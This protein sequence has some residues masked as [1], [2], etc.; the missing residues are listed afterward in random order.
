MA[1]ASTSH[2]LQ[3]ALELH[4]RGA[5]GDA[6]M[7]YAEVLQNDPANSDAYYYLGMVAC[8]EGR[9]VDGVEFARKSLDNDPQNPR[10]QVLLGRALSALGRRDEALRCF[11]RAIGLAPQLAQAHASRADVL[12][13][14]GRAAEA[15]ES[16]D[17]ALSLLPEAA[18]DW[19][20][21]GIALCMLRRLEEAITSF[22]RAI[23]NKPDIAQMH[24][25]RAKV[26]SD[27][28]RYDDALASFEKALQIEPRL[29]EAWVDRATV[30]KE[31]KQYSESLNA[32]D[33][34]LAIK[35]D[36]AEALLCRGNVLFLLKRYDKALAVCDQA[37]ALRPD[38]AE[39]HFGRGAIFLA[40]KQY[41]DAL[42][43]YEAALNFRPDFAEAAIACGNVFIE[44]KQYD[45]ALAAN[46]RAASLRPDIAEAWAGCGNA[47]IELRRYDEALVA[48]DRAVTL[49]PALAEAWLGRANVFFNRKQYL[50]ALAAF[51]SAISLQ[52]DLA[53]GWAGR[54]N[55]LVELRRY[56]EALAACD[57]ASAL[58]PDLLDAW[59]GRA[60]IFFNC[61][62]Y[63]DAA[64]ACERILELKP[65]FAR[66]WF[67]YGSALLELQ[68]CDRA[69]VAYDKATALGPETDYAEGQR[70]LAKLHMCDWSALEADTRL[71]LS[72]I[73]EQKAASV[74]FVLLPLPS[75]AAEQLQCA[76]RF[77]QDLPS[78]PTV[79]IRR[80][81]AHDRIRIAYLSA[82]F[83]DHAVAHLVAGLF[84]HHDRSRFE[85]TG[86]SF[87]RSDSSAVRKRIV[88][89]LDRFVDIQTRP[90]ADAADLMRQLEIDIA[91]DL[92]GHTQSARLGILA[93]RPAP[94][95]I[96]Y[97][98]YAGTLGTE[99]FDY[100][101]GDSTVIP[102]SHR[103]FFAEQ[104]VWLPDSYF[105]SDDRRP[106]SQ[107][108]LIRRE[109]SL[110]E[111]GF[112]YCSFNNAYKIT[113]ELF[114]IWM[115]LLRATPDSVL[116]LSE[117]NPPA[118]LNLRR[119]AERWGVSPQRLI[120]AP[121]ISDNSE[122]L[123][124]Q[125]HADL[126]LDTLP[127]NAHTTAS[128]ALWAGLP[129]LTCLGETFAGRVAAS[130][131]KAVG[132]PEL[133]T[134]SLD[135]YEALALKLAREPAVLQ[136]I[137]SKLAHNRKTY[138][139]FD[140]ARFTRHLEAAYETMWEQHQK[141]EPPA[142]FAVKPIT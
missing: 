115:R 47:L 74:P 88:G 52:P 31:L 100:I 130:L 108:D 26:L 89:S 124:R 128:D 50:D 116:W 117:L 60:N 57:K 18:E 132:L 5:L 24:Y 8:Q 84:E 131:L 75:T 97:L 70:L 103:A 141:G 64:A 126:F 43:A 68:H 81:R 15:V 63:G 2:L 114:H 91:V 48:C 49:K 9:F 80:V 121:K 7:R 27:L 65:D 83:R 69:F 77:A 92:M 142:G 59:L 45:K 62:R 98:G 87:G 33:R 78:S 4:R 3:E 12:T 32:C 10:A 133:I 104:V 44:L 105:V 6:S 42:S 140:T 119:E 112:V 28:R 38:F 134:T 58:K 73:R 136:S 51:D 123:A 14:L 34:A 67:S 36:Y 71:L 137:K 21:R 125:R 110:P 96:F 55:T 90:D 29:A 56:D 54:G 23:E 19:F 79:W 39:A 113:P 86:L 30:F 41:G 17:K 25:M 109:C 102:E 85:I 111:N 1:S 122:H 66:A 135:E 61:Q 138:P 82:D 139:L 35:P 127:Y 99:F 95:Q 120:F 94:I 53:Q 11:E 46:E 37:L 40:S 93:Q 107:K 101:I 76:A 72:Q 20:N 16:Y 13:D 22:D 106:I 118:Q 129:V